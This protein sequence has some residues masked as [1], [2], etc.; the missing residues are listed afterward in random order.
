MTVQEYAAEGQ[1]LSRLIDEA[2]E[3]LSA[4]AVGCATFER[5]YRRA[6][7]E[8]WGKAPEGTVPVREAWVNAEVGDQ[9]FERDKAEGE[10]VSALESLRSRRAQLSFLQT[11]M[12]ATSEDMQFHA[13]GQAD[14]QGAN[15]EVPF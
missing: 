8:A 5:E 10:R 4:A 1:R 7:A 2:V 11:L 3:E 6:K 14:M 9:R 13:T 15:E 12:K